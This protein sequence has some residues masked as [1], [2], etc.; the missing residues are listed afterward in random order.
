MVSVSRY[1]ESVLVL[2]S[3]PFGRN[4]QRRRPSCHEQCTMPCS[5]FICGGMDSSFMIC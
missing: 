3:G 4:I 2:Q 1:L 5:V